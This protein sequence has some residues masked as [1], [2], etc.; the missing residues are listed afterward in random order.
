MADASEKPE[1]AKPAVKLATPVK[2]ATAQEEQP[3]AENK[4]VENKPAEVVAPKPVAK[5]MADKKPTAKT[6]KPASKAKK[7]SAKPAPKPVAAKPA[8][9][10]DPVEESV[11][12]VTEF[13]GE[14][15]SIFNKMGFDMF[16]SYE[17]VVAFNK[18]NMEAVV[19]SS[20]ILSEGL[21]EVSEDMVAYAQASVKENVEATKALFDCKDAKA[22]ADLQ[23]KIA[24]ESYDKFLAEAGKISSA[25]TKLAEDAWA[26]I[27]ARVNVAFEA[28]KG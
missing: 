5:S 18:D 24:K 23:A 21:K 12:D 16:K 2:S 9:V 22:L 14:Q 13:V 11:E 19:K 7:A 4:P 8:T 20:S 25:S 27:T 1:T 6:A 26:P 28:F 3:K 15:F 17:D 10:V